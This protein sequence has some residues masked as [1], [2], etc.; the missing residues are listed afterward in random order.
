MRLPASLRGALYV[1]GG[2]VAASGVVWLVVHDASRRVAVAC[3]EVHGTT[4]MALLVLTGAVV[5]L[6][7]ATGWRE[8][9]NRASGA[10][11]STALLIVIATG[12]LLYY[13]GDEGARNLASVTH[14]VLGL[15]AIALTGL[16]VWFGQ[17]GARE[18]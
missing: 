6:H 7:A 18:G 8:R 17:R 9:R 14:W 3:M 1:T 5:A 2:V 11:L 13:V 4:A 12:A 16:H 15:A 10:I